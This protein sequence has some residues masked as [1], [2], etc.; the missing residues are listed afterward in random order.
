[1]SSEYHEYRPYCYTD[2]RSVHAT[3][4]RIALFSHTRE[5]SYGS[6]IVQLYSIV[7]APPNRPRENYRLWL[8]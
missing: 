7:L 2:M 6:R 5:N 8:K 4:Y 3:L 1:M